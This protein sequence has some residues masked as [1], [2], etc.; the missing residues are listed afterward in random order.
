MANTG[1]PYTKA[2]RSINPLAQV[3]LWDNDL[4]TIQW[5]NGTTPIP[6]ADIEAKATE[7]ETRD[8]HIKPRHKAYP[9]ITDQLDMQYHDKVDGT[10]TWEDAIQEVKDAN[11][12][13]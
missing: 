10:T 3:Q 11:P 4:N 1:K 8:A 6:L 13:A 2:I 9:S 7:I 5:N 12:K